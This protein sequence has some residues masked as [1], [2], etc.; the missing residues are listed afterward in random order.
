MRDIQAKISPLI[1]SLFPSFYL[2]EGEDFV[3]FVEA[4][5]EWLET[6]HQQLEVTSNTN[7][8]VGDTVTQGNTTGNVVAVEGNN[9]LVSVDGFDAFRCNIQCDEYLPISTSSGG[10][11]YVEKQYKINPIYY[12]RKLFDIRDVDRTLDQ[13]IVH[14]KEQYLKNIEFDTNTNKRLLI[15]NS[16]DLYRSKGTER[17]VD[18]FFRLIYGS[19][20]TVYYPGEDLMRLSAAQWYK[21]LYIEITNSPRTLDLVGKQITGVKS[22]ASAFV[23]KYIKRR[24]KDGFVYVL[25]IS[26]VSGDFV[27][28]ELLKSDTVYYNLPKVV[29]SLNGLTVLSGSKL[30][31]VG[32][33]VTFTSTR[34]AEA[35]GRISGISNIT[36]VVDFEMYD[37]GW[38]YTVSAP[39]ADYSLSELAKRSQAIV[40]TKVLTLSNVVTSNTIAGFVIT[41]GGTGYSNSDTIT[42]RSN[43][44]NCTATVNTDASGVIT[45]INMNNPGAGFFTASPTVTITTSG[46]STASIQATTKAFPTYFKYFEKSTQRLANVQYDTAINKNAFVAGEAVYIGN[47]TA[48]LAFGTILANEVGTGSNGILT[49][50]IANNGLFGT[51]NTITLNSNT[52]VKANVAAITNTSAT[53]TVMGLP[54]TANLS[55]S[56]ITGPFLKDEE[57][58]QLDAGGI[59]VANGIVADTF[60]TGATG[61]I[62]VDHFKGVFKQSASLPVYIRHN[63]AQA[64]VTNIELT[65]GLYTVSNTFV[66]TYS[67]P[68]FST[69]TATIANVISVSAGSGANFEV[70][71]I[72]D[73]ETIYLNTD[74]L[75]GNGTFTNAL[76]QAFMTI[77]INN[78]EYGFTKNKAGNSASVIFD[79]LTFD[80]FTIGTIATLTEINPGADYTVDPYVLVDQ[81]Y[82]SGF[83]LND[84]I[85]QLGSISGQFID[86]ERLL[87]TS[88]LLSKTTILLDNELGLAVGEKVIQGSAN[89]IIDTIQATANT[90][91]VKGVNGTFQANAT[92]LTSAS[93]GTFSATVSSVST[94]SA[95]TST[96]KGIVKSSNSTHVNVKR[97]QFDNLFQPAL[98]VTGQVSG[99]TAT[100]T[101]V[102]EDESVLPIGLNANVYAN[103]V[104]ANGS[105]TNIDINDSG[106]GYKTGEELIYI[107]ED[108][109]R[110]GS[111]VANVFG[112]GTGSGYYKD[113]KG[114]VSSTAK[115]QDGDYYQEYSYEVLSRIPLDRYKDM[116]KKVMHTAG[117]RFFGGVV[118]EDK[119]GANVAYANSIVNTF[120]PVNA[121]SF[122]AESDVSG[123]TITLTA[124]AFAN[125]MKVNYYA[126]SS[127]TPLT[128]LGNNNVYYIANT[129]TNT[130]KL[131]TNPRIFTYSFNSNSAVT[132]TTKRLFNANSAL[133]DATDAIAIPF[134]NS[135]YLP[136]DMVLYSVAA[137]N[138]AL[139]NLTSGSYY[140]IKTSN[141]TAV[142]LAATSG[143]ATIDLTK[144]LTE[145][146]H[147]LTGN[148]VT[149]NFITLTR[150]NLQNNDVVKYLV[151]AGNTA[152]SPLANNTQ[153]YVVSANSAG[154]KLSSSR[155]GSAI[156]ITKGLTENGHS[157][158]IT[159][160]NITDGF[161]ETGHF[162]AQVNET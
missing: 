99:A 33:I 93:N 4:Y 78:L 2:D 140:Y 23:E 144:G 124:H 46:G 59:E 61:V 38:G 149:T 111:A 55:I 117:T 40:S 31:S 47:T 5:Y 9:I 103:V 56:A 161:S 95:I 64:T 52:A 15:K 138:T 39:T 90:I 91:I 121:D 20:A 94:N 129:T 110:T 19:S 120:D 71:S 27:N 60:I 157:L 108:G 128:E 147:S 122:N 106:L 62:K 83:G 67:A 21:P 148:T 14:F 118:L 29:G 42:V 102:I 105:V 101:S 11:T 22:G 154:V 8:V 3:A 50:S 160:I 26:N 89:G 85:I 145:D 43:Y 44:T 7:I 76:S 162:I 87:Q 66:N 80:S 98:T 131:T 30:F 68:V 6:N 100:I 134:A 70:G 81:P 12:A 34:G 24:V 132:S 49:I 137:G 1:K 37:G 17:S 48:N 65:V 151:T 54:Y 45:N 35:T 57:V 139:T 116:F 58:Y 25:Y 135:V 86:G 158:G 142:T 119:F 74:R 115:V 16:F 63:G 10:N 125:G 69:N 127:N 72:T 92:A 13:F 77:P 143:G 18:L 146:G 109:L 51:S 75:A 153:Y 82:L 133:T 150:H 36:G 113:T 159:T 114:Q 141:T 88:T 104:T 126:H 32:D 73:S 155:G 123:D 156:D 107:S 112:I 28:N 152:V 79:C 84:Y 96:A 130:V 97:I 41:S 53:A 136:G